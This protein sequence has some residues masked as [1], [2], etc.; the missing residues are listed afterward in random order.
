MRLC[1]KPKYN[2][3]QDLSGKHEYSFTGFENNFTS[4]KI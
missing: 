3:L 2:I 4:D 1:N